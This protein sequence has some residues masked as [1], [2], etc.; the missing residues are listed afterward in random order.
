MTKVH[1]RQGDTRTIEYQTG[2]EKDPGKAPVAS[3]LVDSEKS[4]PSDLSDSQ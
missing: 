3:Y 1:I 2:V 4:K